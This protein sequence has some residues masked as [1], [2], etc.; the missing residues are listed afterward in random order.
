M[1]VTRWGRAALANI[2]LYIYRRALRR[3]DA[4][5]RA[6]PKEVPP[7]G[8]CED[9]GFSTWLYIN[10]CVSGAL[11]RSTPRDWFATRARGVPRDRPARQHVHTVADVAQEIRLS[12]LFLAW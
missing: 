1:Q 4:S 6:E 7:E 2:C 12:T 8:E 5:Y 9:V 3:A 10:A 11:S